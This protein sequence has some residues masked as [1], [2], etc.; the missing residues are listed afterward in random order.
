[1]LI[2]SR[3]KEEQIVIGDDVVVTI[4]DLDTDKVKI[5]IDAPKNVKVFRKELIEDVK[6]S[7]VEAVSASVS[8]FGELVEQMEKNK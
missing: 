6:S 1:M 5:G 8:M 4:I 2:L 3:K 7:N